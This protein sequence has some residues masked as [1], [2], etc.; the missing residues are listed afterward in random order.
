MHRMWERFE[1]IGCDENIEVTLVESMLIDD[2]KEWW[3]TRKE[4]LVEEAK[5]NWDVLQS[6]FGREYFSKHYQKMRLR[7]MK[8]VSKQES[9]WYYYEEWEFT[10]KLERKKQCYKCKKFHKGKCVIDEIECYFC[11]QN[12]QHKNNCLAFSLNRQ[13]EMGVIFATPS[14]RRQVATSIKR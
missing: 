2:A 14:I 12:G 1:I 3:F 11:C 6:M 9:V 8:E 4:D 10:S 13:V 5:Q 7:E